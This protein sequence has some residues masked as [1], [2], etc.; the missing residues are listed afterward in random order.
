MSNGDNMATPTDWIA[1]LGD[2]IV[3]DRPRFDTM[4]AYYEARQPG[5]LGFI[6][7]EVREQVGHR[8]TPVIVNWPRLAI[9]ALE[10]RLAI[11]GFRIGENDAPADERLW[12][13]WLENDLDH[14]SKLAHLDALLYGRAYVS[15]WAGDNPDVP[16]IRVESARQVSVAY[17]PGTRRRIAA[18]KL[19]R[20]DGY[21]RA[22]V[23]LPDRIVRARTQ[24]HVPEGA[25]IPPGQGWTVS[26]TIP[27]PLGEVPVV[28]LRNR[29]RLLGSGESELVDVIPLTDAISKLASDMMVSAEFHAMPRRWATGL[30][31]PEDEEGEVDDP[32]DRQPG[33]T[34]MAE[35]PETKFG[36][37]PEATLDGFVAGV[38]LLTQQLA[39]VTSI[40]A[41]YLNSLT[42][43]LPSAESLRAAEASLVTKVRD[44]QSAFGSAWEDVARLASAV[45]DGTFPEIRPR[46]IWRDPETRTA[47]QAA[48][49]ALKRS[50]LGVPFAQLMEDLGYT[51]EQIAKMRGQRRS[52]A[53]D[54][55]GVTFDALTEAS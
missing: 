52:D 31:L 46:I 40:P 36:Q 15:V 30:E 53:L 27:N 18:V 42:G 51:P 6:A 39:S 41:H 22:L 38:E 13:W 37:F 48:D 8:L 32:F 35:D 33:R 47:G 44:R 54:R 3:T 34:W 24:G 16:S 1:R 10:E 49:A 20:E 26:E 55:T 14:G 17:A 9:G 43:Q 7:P 2:R 5:A 19:W 45:V 28:E 21:G 50:E 25:E 23:F 11:N 29:G 12:S 4:D